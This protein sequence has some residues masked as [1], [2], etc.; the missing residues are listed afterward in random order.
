MHAK[1]TSTASLGSRAFLVW[2]YCG[3]HRECEH[4]VR[5]FVAC[6]SKTATKQYLIDIFFS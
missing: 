5:L 3:P 1:P 6:D 2:G 4:L